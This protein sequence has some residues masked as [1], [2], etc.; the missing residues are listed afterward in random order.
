LDEDGRPMRLM[1]SSP[2]MTTPLGIAPVNY[3]G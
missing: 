1:Y 2:K 3:T